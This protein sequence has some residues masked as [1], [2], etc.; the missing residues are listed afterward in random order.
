MQIGAEPGKRTSLRKKPGGEEVDM[1]TSRE[2]RE[3]DT[4][5]KKKVGQRIGKNSGTLIA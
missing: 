5:E 2:I 4:W 3:G 1:E